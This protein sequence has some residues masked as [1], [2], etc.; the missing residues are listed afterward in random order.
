MRKFSMS[1]THIVPATATEPDIS[2]L[3]GRIGAQIGNIR[4][5]GELPDAT[6]AAIEASLS[7][8]KVIFFKN[9]EHLDDAGQERFAARFGGLVAHPTTPARLGSAAIL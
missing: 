2:P 3:S 7:K 9:Q 6:I 1:V 5:S 8:Y 4:P